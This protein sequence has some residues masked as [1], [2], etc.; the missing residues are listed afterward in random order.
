MA[1]V[2][3]SFLGPFE[4]IAPLGA[5]GMGEVYRARDTRLDRSV[6]IKILPAHLSDN[7]EAKQRFDR[8]ARSISS[9]N[10][11]NICTLY[12]VG[13]QDGID[14]L[15][16][17]LL[18]GETLADRL[19]KGPLPPAQVLKYGIEICAGLERAHKT[20]VVHRD[21]KPGNIML[22]KS[23]AKL[24]DFGLAKIA[25][26]TSVALTPS[27]LTATLSNPAARSHPLTVEG[28]VIGTFQYMS[29]EQIEGKEADQRSDIF[30]LGAVLYE[31]ATGKRAFEGKTAA[32]VIGAVLER[33]PPLISMIRPASPPALDRVVQT[34]L[35]KDPDERFQSVHDVKLQLEWIVEAVSR[36]VENA[37]NSKNSAGYGR[38]PW[39]MAGFATLA[40]AALAFA[41]ASRAPQQTPIS[42]RAEINPHGEQEYGVFGPT[43]NGFALSPDAQHIVFSAEHKGIS[44]LYLRRLDSVASE[45]LPGTEDGSFPFWSS[46]SHSIGFFA[47]GKLKKFELG[48]TTT[49]TICDAPSGRGGAWSPSG[50]IV[51]TPDINQPLYRIPATGGVATPLTK[52]DKSHDE[53]SN[54][55]PQFLP[56]GDH[57]I[58][59][60][61]TPLTSPFL[62]T[63]AGGEKDSLRV[64]SLDNQ[65]SKTLRLI[66]GQAQYA[67]GYLLYGGMDDTLVAQR[68]DPAKLQF[69]GDPL[70]VVQEVLRY[71]T[72][73]RRFFSVSDN[74]LLAYIQTDP[75]Q[76]R[77]FVLL[78]RS[79]KNIATLAT[80]LAVAQPRFSP[81][82]KRIAF[83][84]TAQSSREVWT[85]DISRAVKN[86]L[87]FSKD[88]FLSSDPVWSPDGRQ[89][90]FG[91][92]RPGIYSVHR[93]NSDG[94]GGDAVILPNDIIPKWPSDWSADGK[95]LSL[96]VGSSLMYTGVLIA[97]LSGS[98]A[99][100][101]PPSL[102]AGTSINR[103][104]HF[105]P[106]SK[107]ISYTSLD[108]GK[109]EIYVTPFPSSGGKY[110]VST[111]GGYSSAWRADGKEIFYIGL[112]PENWLTVASVTRKGE[113][114]EFGKP[115]KLFQTQPV[116]HYPFDVSPDGQKFVFVN[117]GDAP[118]APIVLV[119]NWTATLKPK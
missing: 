98:P 52:L 65:E 88:G 69:K 81:D 14:F 105:S 62:S 75:Q 118:P 32:T 45:Q 49:V 113:S 7:P 55:W 20:G 40:A 31:M 117:A 101:S 114:L 92:Y 61:V 5:G 115:Q 74:G 90:A 68:F 58:Y 4:I 106:D 6:A 110:Q 23:G 35:T 36:T 97:P 107:W 63:A 89:L 111:E 104:A 28:T 34:C 73:F 85:Y 109:S 78:D 102:N 93:T 108:S 33:D 83:D 41:F 100:F 29:P 21:L 76:A 112:P 19:T 59:L 72:L 91:V 66:A 30:A 15:V 60:S 64:A 25:T 103:D 77:P 79:G 2:E 53:Y 86:R 18:E 47:A 67:S 119:T 8:E 82:G 24:M 70:P 57:F 46:D 16:M 26:A 11:P 99:P 38:R 80:D 3:H 10:H 54:R 43:N 94:S 27:S 1:L 44:A 50:V 39:A 12:D 51:F 84:V 17:E 96:T 13:N 22:T 87:T 42:I 56:D 95:Y 71:P 48:A 9:L 116:I 37:N